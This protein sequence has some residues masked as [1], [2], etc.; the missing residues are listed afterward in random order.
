MLTIGQTMDSF[1]NLIRGKQEGGPFTRFKSWEYCHKAFMDV[2]TS[3]GE[4][5]DEVIDNLALHLS[6]YLAS[7]GMYRGS[8]FILQRDYKTHKPIVRIV[9]KHEYDSL[10]EYN[11]E[12]E[13]DE[14][15][16]QKA[17]LLITAYKDIEQNGYGPLP[18]PEKNYLEDNN[19]QEDDNGTD[20]I[21]ITLITKILMGTFAVSPAFDRFFRD[22]IVKYNNHN[23]NNMGCGT[24]YNLSRYF[25]ECSYNLFVFAKN[26]STELAFPNN[27]TTSISYPIM[28]KVD[29][30]FWEV[31]Y[32]F[33]FI[34]PLQDT[35][36]K[37]GESDSFDRNDIKKI[38]P[39]IRLINRISSFIPDVRN[40]QGSDR[41]IINSLIRDI[42][43][44]VG[45][46]Q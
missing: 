43:T 32:E 37:L 5:T 8:S 45:V 41:D 3:Q 13:E 25:E 21:S 35:L 46:N 6:F 12:G 24:H 19:N 38:I 1:L 17:R 27:V 11:P 2:H 29:M 14:A 23:D 40:R 42:R 22:G 28:K 34:K 15:L 39:Y 33:G 7:W 9:F 30:Y 31:G 44:R 10:W 20:P 16:K 26:H 18:I 4:L 36:E